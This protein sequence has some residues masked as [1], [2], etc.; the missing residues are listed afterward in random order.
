MKMTRLLAA[1]LLLMTSASLVHGQS[2][3]FLTTGAS[4]GAASYLGNSITHSEKNGQNYFIFDGPAFTVV[5]SCITKQIAFFVS[6][7]DGYRN[8][9]VCEGG[10]VGAN[11]GASCT[12]CTAAVCSPITTGVCTN[13]AVCSQPIPNTYDIA[14]YCIGGP[15]HFGKMYAHV[16]AMD[17][18]TFFDCAHH[19]GECATFGQ[20]QKQYVLRLAWQ[21]GSVVLDPGNYAIGMAT[22]C[23]D[24][25]QAIKGRGF[26][27]THCATG[28]G[29]GGPYGYDGM[30]FGSSS[31]SNAL[32][33]FKAGTQLMPTKYFTQEQPCLVYDNQ[34]GLPSDIG[35]GSPCNFSKIPT[36]GAGQAP[37]ILT[38]AL[39]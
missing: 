23:D 34:R 35:P 2:Q 4:T 33:R 3:C 36:N 10:G 31:P 21:G 27:D 38:F 22:S 26:G 13:G 30:G 20:L 6:E 8:H 11:N 1:L 12:T 9:Y 17:V 39:Y 32:G 25:K 7:V 28:L 18:N 29:E 14:I 24:G 5:N 16:G 37:H 19:G 15:C